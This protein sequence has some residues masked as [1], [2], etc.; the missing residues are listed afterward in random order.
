MVER[1]MQALEKAADD[2]T[3]SKLIKDGCDL[4][5]FGV[6]IGEL[7]K[8]IKQYK[9]KNNNRLAIELIET[10]NF[11]AM[12]LGFLIMNPS[13]IDKMWFVK[14]SGY[15]EYYRIR[16][17]SLAY[18]MAEH[19]EYEY[20]LERFKDSQSDCELSIYYAIIAG[21]VIID[22]S[23]NYELLVSTSS[24][25]AENINSENYTNFPL[26]RFEMYSL[27]GYIGIQVASLSNQM[28]DISKRIET[29]FFND[30]PRRL[31]NNVLFI[32]NAVQR[33]AVGKKR[34]SARC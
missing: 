34:K 26:T 9:L 16:I 24:E 32:E 11:D 13:N 25:I 2:K 17:Y 3:K 5:L 7:K 22:P 30:T 15:S 8:L 21:R 31:G 12:Y 1:L 19:Q 6:K 28:I 23:F 29:N 10:K 18:A 33:N 14:W 4:E 20:F 27:L